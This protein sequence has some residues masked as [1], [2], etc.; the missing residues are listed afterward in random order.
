MHSNQKWLNQIQMYN[1]LKFKNQGF[2]FWVECATVYGNNFIVVR[3]VVKR[4]NWLTW[5]DFDPYE[6]REPTPEPILKEE[7][8]AKEELN[9][10]KK[11][12]LTR[13]DLM[14]EEK[15][16]EMENERQAIG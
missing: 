16:V 15:Q 14:K 3:N 9:S 13:K 10:R 2:K 8:P 7:S 1:I 12:T 11:G 6:E 4:R 5:I